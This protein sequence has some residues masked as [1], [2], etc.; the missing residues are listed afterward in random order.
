[1]AQLTPIPLQGAYIIDMPAFA[2]ARGSFIKTFHATTLAQQGIAFNLRESYFSL[3][4]KD[5]VRGMHFQTPPHQHA[6]VVFC[7][8]G[9]IVDVIVDLR[10]GSP[11]YGQHFA[12]ELSA[13]NH[14]AYYIPEGFAHGFKALTDDAITYYL[15][16]SEYSQPNDTGIRY[17]SIG[18]NWGTDNPIISDR[19]LSFPTLQDFNSPF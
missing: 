16:S 15:V 9:A 4:K 10:K 19:D 7:P 3:S 1:M 6:K 18:Y 17:D 8:Q 5:V 2:D 13:A 14:K 11:T 12:T